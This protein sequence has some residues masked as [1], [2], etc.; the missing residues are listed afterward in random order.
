MLDGFLA[1]AAEA[2]PAD[3]G[4]AD[5]PVTAGRALSFSTQAVESFKQWDDTFRARDG[6]VGDMRE[7]GR[8]FIANRPGES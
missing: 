3:S 2:G 6:G 1:E 8:Q 5:S 7:S 4:A